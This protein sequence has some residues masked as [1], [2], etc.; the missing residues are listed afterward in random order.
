MPH[1]GGRA[2]CAFTNEEPPV[3]KVWC[4]IGKKITFS[5]AIRKDRLINRN[6]QA[7]DGEGGEGGLY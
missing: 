2:P 6:A 5:I 4:R 3:N 1:G 7:P